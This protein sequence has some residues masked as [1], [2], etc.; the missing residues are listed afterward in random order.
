M[1]LG[2][3]D[4][5]ERISSVDMQWPAPTASAVPGPQILLVDDDAMIQRLIGNFLRSHGYAVETADSGTTMRAAIAACRPDL[6]VLDLAM[7]DEN[8]LSLLRAFTGDAPPVIV[9]SAQATDIDRII[10]LELGADDYLAKPC[11]P[12]ELL[13]R[14]RTVLRRL[15]RGFEKR[16]SNGDLLCFAGW[17]LDTAGRLLTDPAGNVIT[18]TS[19]EFRLLLS[20]AERPRRV[21]SRDRLLD[22]ALG[23]AEI[24]YRTID[25]H[26]CR[27]RRKLARTGEDELI[28]T[29][30]SE[31]YVFV[32]SV[33]R[34]DRA[35]FVSV[36]QALISGSLMP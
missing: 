18:L 26:V 24:F 36:D 21:L 34:R 20:F 6:I 8:G 23:D 35:Q 33:M 27:L 13:A 12:R 11:N 10:G 5:A 19:A 30:R 15:G 32:P 14:I 1:K 9:L 31:G 16:G 2:A 4:A 22:L 17:V 3:F 28:H 29:M 25:A 7:P